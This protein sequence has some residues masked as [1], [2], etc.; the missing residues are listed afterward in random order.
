MG[1]GCAYIA[2]AQSPGQLLSP[3]MSPKGRP[4]VQATLWPHAVWTH[5][6]QKGPS[7]AV[8]VL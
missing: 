4:A 8:V 7:I 5:G 2:E 1:A 6:V 3:Q